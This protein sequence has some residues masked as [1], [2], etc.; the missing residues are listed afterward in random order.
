MFLASACGE[1]RVDLLLPT[2]I[3]PDDTVLIAVGGARP[4]VL[5]TPARDAILFAEETDVTIELLHYRL[6]LGSLP[7]TAGELSS[8]AEGCLLL[9]GL[10]PEGVW[11]TNTSAEGAVSWRATSV[12]RVSALV[13]SFRLPAE[14]CP[15]D[16]CPRWEVERFEL[17]QPADN[18]A[19]SALVPGGPL[20]VGTIINRTFRID[21]DESPPRVTRLG[22]E[23]RVAG[24]RA[25][26]IDGAGALWL[27][28][29][30]QVARATVEAER[31]LT[32]PLPS[33]PTA[34]PRLMGGLSS[35]TGEGLLV[36]TE[37]G[38]F[39][40][41]TGQG[42]EVLRQDLAPIG[43]ETSVRGAIVPLGTEQAVAVWNRDRVIL[44]Y[45]QGEVRDETPRALIEGAVGAASVE[46]LGPVVVTGLAGQVL[47]HD[48]TEWEVFEQ[49]SGL[50][51]RG[52]AA[53]DDGFVIVADTGQFRPYLL[54][55]GW[56]SSEL[57]FASDIRV[58]ER[59]DRDTYVVGG[60]AIEGG[61]ELVTPMAVLRRRP[62]E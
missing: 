15:V 23:P 57:A 54:A 51:A 30:T 10:P 40:R 22:L 5:V 2:E 50:P 52:I 34:R 58:A 61:P 39:E 12:E 55:H 9:E 59:I 38:T 47:R 24:V 60:N 14:Q 56:C 16:P 11:T 53:M 31:L 7:F 3:G 42:W 1:R 25:A 26:N 35:T 28:G 18:L 21:L 4:R 43:P 48:G 33:S 37:A 36:M 8:A 6:P 41:Y 46:G 29:T 45:V 32:E 44:R 27:A 62:R 19:W 13:R 17:P 20:V 49:R